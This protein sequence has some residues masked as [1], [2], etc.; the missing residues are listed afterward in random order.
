MEDVFISYASENRP[1]AERLAAGL[2]QAGYSVWLDRKVGGEGKRDNTIEEALTS[3]KCVVVL[4]TGHAKHSPLV[5]AEAR[6]ALNQEKL[7]LILLEGNA[8]PIPFTGIQALNFPSWEGTAESKEFETLHRVIQAKIAG[9]AIE[10]SGAPSTH[11]SW[12]GNIIAGMGMKTRIGIA[13]ALLLIASSLWPVSPEVAVHVETARMEISVMAEH[14]DKRL[15]DTLAFD[16]LTLQNIGRISFKP[17]R[18]LV[19]D[20]RDY[21]MASDSYPPKAWVE[22]PVTNQAIQFIP[23]AP[24]NSPEVTIE[25]PEG[26]GRFAGVLDGMILTGDTVVTLEVTE[27]NAIIWSMRTE[28]GQQRAVLSQVQAVALITTGLGLADEATI[29]LPQNQEVTYQAL[30]EH[31]PGILEIAGQDQELIMILKKEQMDE[32]NV[33]SRSVLPVQSV[34]F[35]WQDPGTGERK[36]P[37]GFKGT[38]EYRRPQGMPPEEIKNN[39]FLTLNELDHFEI[40]SIKVNPDTHMLAVDMQGEAGELRAGTLHNPRDLRPTVYDLLRYNPLFEQVKKL[41]GL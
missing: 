26:E 38:V 9:K 29:P 34:D 20:P 8:L 1:V 6:E 41:V 40:T 21:D 33:F 31:T 28:Q 11:A 16:R 19:A 10:L 13:L 3:A 32:V 14:E 18:L 4:W 24:E 27:D 25:S 36:A 30:Y 12:Y 39:S 17:D 23:N 37:E 22:V 35:S 15:T 7:I 2:K 5:Q